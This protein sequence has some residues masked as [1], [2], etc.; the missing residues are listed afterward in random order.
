MLEQ[1]QILV[2]C[3][4]VLNTTVIRYIKKESIKLF[5][6]LT[7]RLAVS[8]RHQQ[9][10]DIMLAPPAAS[11]MICVRISLCWCPALKI[12]EGKIE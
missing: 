11:A 4:V 9:F 2:P 6:S 7:S 5:V 8:R 3:D 1:L 10:Y 12:G